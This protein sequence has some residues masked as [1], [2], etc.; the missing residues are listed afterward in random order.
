ME[1]D[2]PLV[3]RQ[4]G[5]YVVT[6]LLGSGGMGAVYRARDENLRRDVALKLLRLDRVDDVREADRFQREAQ[7][8]AKIS[9][10]N[11]VAVYGAGKDEGHLFLAMEL[12][13][14][15]PLRQLI[16]QRKSGLAVE[17]ALAIASQL[18]NGLQAAHDGEVIHRDI[19]P[20]NLVIKE[21]GTIKILDFGVAKMAEDVALT[22]AD[23]I[24]GTVE[25]MAPEQIVG[26]KI[27]PAVD[28]YAA[29]VVLY[30]MLTGILPFAGDSPATLVYHQLN[31]EPRPPSFLNPNL[32]RSVDRFVL[33][34]LDKVPEDRF[35]SADAAFNGIEEVSH[36]QQLLTVPEVGAT[37][38]VDEGEELRTRYF[39]SRFTGREI[40]V[41]TLVAHFDALVDGGKVVFLA[42]EAGIGKSR[43]VEEFGR[44]VIENEGRVVKGICFFEHGMGPYMPYLD[45]LASLFAAGEGE[46]SPEERAA[47]ADI[48]QRQAP[49]LAELASSSS[50]TA[51]IRA[52]FAAAF[53]AEA[54]PE[55][56]RQRLFDTIFEVLQTAASQHPL[57]VF[58]EDMHWADEGSLLLLQN[59]ARRAAEA[60]ILWVATYRNEEI[61][62]GDTESVQLENV[63]RQLDSEGRLNEVSLGRFSIPELAK[64]VRSLF[65]ESDFSEEFSKYLHEQS[66]G[67][68]FIALEIL[69]LLRSRDMLYCESGVWTA[70]TGITE[71]VV[72]ERIS[73]LV[74]RRVEQLDSENRELLQIAA[75]IGQQFTSRVL[76]EA[77]G[78]GRID[79]LKSLFKLEKSNQLIVTRNGY[80]EFTHSK[81]REV[82]YAEM[83][84]ELRCEYHKIVAAALKDQLAQGNEVSDE[85]L[86]TH[87][88]FAEDFDAALPYL[89]RGADEAFKLFDWRGSIRLFECAGE[90]CRKGAG[91][92]DDLLHA[93]SFG[94]KA[95]VFLS[96]LEQALESCEEMRQAAREMARPLEEAEA[97]RLMGEANE[98]LRR[99]A[100]ASSHYKDALQCLEGQNASPI[101]ARV[102]TSWGCIDFECGRYDEAENRWKAA[103]E[104]LS[105]TPQETGDVLNNMAV[106]A[107]VRG[108]RDEAWRLYERVLAIDEGGTVTWQKMMTL[109][110]MGMLRADEERWDE[111]L[112]LYSRSMDVCHETRYFF[113]QSDIELSRSEALL[114]A[115]ERN[116]AQEACSR[117]LKGYRRRDDPL[118]VAD[119][120]K[121]YGRFCRLEG[122]W[123]DGKAYLEKSIE[124]NRQFGESVSL[125]EALFELGI[126]SRDRGE[127][128][129]ALIPLREAE[130]I[131][132]KIDADAD[133]NRVR[134]ILAELA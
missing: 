44:Y 5:G 18:F 37:E 24:L 6:R 63:L 73:S 16:R 124:I 132:A 56:A 119:A 78:V 39:Q 110:N 34:L 45:A 48:L 68:P 26:D 74:M 80:Y 97:L 115:G 114:G 134:D 67:N 52:S 38:P 23:E 120:L 127:A 117:T 32:P 43:V 103:L 28:L 75:V 118:G 91:S 14:G 109:W 113:H 13:E 122:K 12:V 129:T 87:F 62:S 1:T 30:E 61:S 40:E 4:F 65:L 101:G 96:N 128:D 66:Q 31:E 106:L 112:E 57:V 76:E 71:V 108:Q 131:F 11:V 93:L 35:P 72:P 55:A 82:L 130:S 92:G 125:G 51:K 83:P 46:L 104:I 84:W 85:E 58:L 105:D 36:R 81:I 8:A 90:S 27:G 70:Q 126:L 7:L 22:R 3:G 47:L 17:E 79:L 77:S 121:M 25:Y 41:G 99:F 88:F 102:L 2:D 133:L 86:G 54:N 59:L 100:E 64:L 20:E 69:K 50:T 95:K 94:A 15:Q 10:P 111:A 42:G 98:Q 89:I 19:K 60:Q 33:R 21:D 123:D 116:K 53:G 49:E 9:H 107:T 29:G